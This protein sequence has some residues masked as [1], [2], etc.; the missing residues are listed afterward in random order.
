MTRKLPFIMAIVPLALSALPAAAH[1]AD[2]AAAGGFLT[3]F[4]HPLFGLDHVAA[5]VAVGLWGAILGRPALWVLPVAFPLV[6]AIGGALGV[7]GVPLPGIETGIAA[8]AVVIGLAVALAL[9][10]PVAVAALIVGGFAIFHGHAH[11]TEMPNAASP[12]AYAAGF[13]LAT[14]LLHLAGIVF[15]QLATRP[16][17]M[18]AVRVAG[19]AIALAGVG[20]LSGVL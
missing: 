1:T 17:G 6:M 19:S 12:A 9:R 10:P 2:G 13:V 5:M 18:G 3:G 15:G 4:L 16:A 8:S 7:A 20:F 11:G 14:G